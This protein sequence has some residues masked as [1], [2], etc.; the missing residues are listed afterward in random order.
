M[1]KEVSAAVAIVRAIADV[2]RELDKV[3]SGTLYAM[4]M[5]KFTLDEYNLMIDMMIKH[6]W[7]K[8]SGSHMLTWIG[9]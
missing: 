7:V 3:P 4:L 2:I 9:E 8:R 5:D 6:G 1:S